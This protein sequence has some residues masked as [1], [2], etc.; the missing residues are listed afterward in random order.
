MEM[1]WRND[2]VVVSKTRIMDYGANDSFWWNIKG[3]YIILEHL[4]HFFWRIAIAELAG[5][6]RKIRTDP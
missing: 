2:G 1:R 6:Y 5:I 4:I 3:I